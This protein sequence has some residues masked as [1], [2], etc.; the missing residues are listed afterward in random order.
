VPEI[1]PVVM[2]VG[3]VAFAILGLIAKKKLLYFSVKLSKN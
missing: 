2:A 1:T 3:L